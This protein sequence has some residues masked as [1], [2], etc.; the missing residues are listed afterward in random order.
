MSGKLICPECNGNVYIGSAKDPALVRD[1]LK[2]D[3]QGEVEITEESINE[4][5][6]L[7]KSARLQ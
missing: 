3:N 7:V 4:L 5:L 1:C 2:C 6:D